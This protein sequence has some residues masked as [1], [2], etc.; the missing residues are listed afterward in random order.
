MSHKNELI[1]ILI[2]V[3]NNEKSVRKSI[4]SLQNQSYQNIEILILD[5]ASSD[6]SWQIIAKLASE[7]NRLKCFRNKNNLGL[8]K[9]LN[10]LFSHTN[11]KIF[12]RQ[13]S[14]DY[15]HPNRLEKQIHFLKA[16][17][18]DACTTYAKSIQSKKILHKKT[19]FIPPKYLMKFKNPFIHGTLMGSVESVKSIDYYDEAFFYAQD[20]KLFA[21]LYKSGNNIKILKEELYYL[22]QKNNISELYSEKQAYYANCVKK[23]YVPKIES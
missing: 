10:I 9:S 16:N 3:Y 8:T 23:G 13:D 14:D 1:S 18:L 11:G 19:S 7:D 17:N 4:E 15:S 22:N 5:D 21:D 20:Y 12:A 2:S 6:N